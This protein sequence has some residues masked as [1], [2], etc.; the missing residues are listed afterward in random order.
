MVKVCLGKI[1]ESFVNSNILVFQV[2]QK[3]TLISSV[4]LHRS[5]RTVTGKPVQWRGKNDQQTIQRYFQMG[6]SVQG[7]IGLFKL[8]EL[9]LGGSIGSPSL[10]MQVVPPTAK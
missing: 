7:S 1:V 9:G 5:L 4:I 10:C 2:D 6:P 3:S 8:T